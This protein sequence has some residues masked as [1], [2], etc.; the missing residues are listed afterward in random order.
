METNQSSTK[1]VEEVG[2]FNKFLISP[3]G[4]IIAIIVLIVFLMI[5][6]S[7]ISFLIRERQER[8][9]HVAFELEREWGPEFE[10]YGLVL[11]VPK[12]NNEND[13]LYIYPEISN[14]LINAQ[15]S[16]KYRGIFKANVFTSKVQSKAKFQLEKISKLPGNEKLI[17]AKAR[18]HLITGKNT[19]FKELSKFNLYGSELE[20]AG[21]LTKHKKQYC[22][23]NYFAIDPSIQQ[24]NVAFTAEVNGTEEVIYRP[25]SSKSNLELKTNWKD[26][27]F[28]GNSLPVSS[29]LKKEGEIVSAQWKNLSQIGNQSRTTLNYVDFGNRTSSEIKFITLLD[30]YQL[31]ERTIKYAIL[32]LTLTFAVFF[33][34]QIGGKNTFHPLHYLMIGLALLLFY[35]LLLSL[36]EHLGFNYAYLASA[37]MIVSL[38]T[39]YAKSILGSLKFALTCALSLS[40]LYAFL[41][42]LVNLEVYALLV[43][44][45]GL[46][47]VLA[48]IMSV[49]RK[50]NL[51]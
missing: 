17:W 15:V 35:S 22:Y 3:L 37:F 11:E 34:V 2:E 29:S 33:L 16:E 26:P 8:Q 7:Q 18:L 28:S 40:L 41:L 21:Q 23:S 24:L 10:Y 38:V 25:L 46:L 30:Q 50:L 44:S 32:V 49:T 20:V 19:R 43:G 5:P 9:E 48:A 4:Q 1:K 31:N 51:K 12:S 42:V 27:S 13:V 14:E 45:I 36:S 39:W 47:V 6:A